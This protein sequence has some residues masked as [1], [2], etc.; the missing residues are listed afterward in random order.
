MSQ[1]GETAQFGDNQPQHDSFVGAAVNRLDKPT[2]QEQVTVRRAQEAWHRLRQ[3][4]SWD[5][6]KP[7][8]QR[9]EQQVGAAHVLGRVLE[10]QR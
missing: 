5:D 3:D 7:A 10:R 4:Q 6:W 8:A 1:N 9:P 2:D